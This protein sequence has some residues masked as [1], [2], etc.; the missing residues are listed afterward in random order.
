M[1]STSFD[2][3]ACRF[4]IPGTRRAALGMVLG[5]ALL[6]TAGRS[7]TAR[8]DRQRRNKGRRKNAGRQRA[9]RTALGPNG[10]IPHCISP[11]GLDLNA[12]YGVTEQVAATFCPAIRTGRPWRPASRW[13]SAV[14]YDAYD[15]LPIGF[16]PVAARPQEDFIAKFQAVTYVIDP[17]TRQEKTVTF[18]KSAS[19]FMVQQDDLDVTS[20]ITLGVLQPLSVGDHAVDVHWQLSAMHCDGFGDTIGENCLAAGDYLYGRWDFRVM[21]GHS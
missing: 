13:D 18:P 19:L 12:F 11:S 14:N 6:G 8:K 16:E 2:A 20:P 4:A 15:E 5:T 10:S 9:D 7:V 21:P 1:G 3:L 17:G